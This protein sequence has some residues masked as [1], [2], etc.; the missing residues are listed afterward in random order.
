VY[1]TISAV[2]YKSDGTYFV[3]DGV[4]VPLSDVLEVLKG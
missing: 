2:R 4:E 3:I 1:G